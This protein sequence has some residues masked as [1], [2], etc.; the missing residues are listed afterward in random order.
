M[1]TA[2][3]MSTIDAEE[4]GTAA[5]FTDQGTLERLCRSSR[6]AGDRWLNSPA[7]S[8]RPDAA[9][10]DLHDAIIDQALETNDP[11]LTKHSQYLALDDKKVRP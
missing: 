7:S 3:S 2:K 6:G 5:P 1:D 11:G 4:A 9:G 8:P 10:G